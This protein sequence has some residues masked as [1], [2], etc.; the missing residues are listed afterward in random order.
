MASEHLHSISEIDGMRMV[1]RTHLA[2]AVSA[3]ALQS[4]VVSFEEHHTRN[5]GALDMLIGA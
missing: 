3:R 4:K 1:M 2:P 5:A